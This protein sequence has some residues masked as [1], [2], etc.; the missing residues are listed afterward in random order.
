[1]ILPI[2]ADYVA[3]FTLLYGATADVDSDVF[4][5]MGVLEELADGVYGIP[6]E[7]LET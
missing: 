6:I 1:M 4:V 7:F 3:E 2:V 5:L